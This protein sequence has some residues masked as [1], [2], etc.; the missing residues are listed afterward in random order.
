MGLD[1]GY[2]SNWR[3]FDGPV[4]RPLDQALVMWGL[5]SVHSRCGLHTRAVT[6][7]ATVIRR[8]QLFRH[9]HSCPGCF[10]LERLPGG[11]Y[12]HWKA[13]PLHGAHPKQTRRRSYLADTSSNSQTKDTWALVAD[14]LF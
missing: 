8:L 9:L 12:T 3:P 10:R 4:T 6:K 7:I 13:P 11:T 1:L 14:R 5:L 2:R